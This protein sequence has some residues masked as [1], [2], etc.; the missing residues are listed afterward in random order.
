[1]KKVLVSFFVLLSIMSLAQDE[2]VSTEKHNKG[3]MSVYWG[4][5]RGFYSNSDIHFSGNDHDFTLSNVVAHD[6]QTPFSLDPYFNP[7]LVTIPQTNFRIGYFISDKWEISIGVD[8][9]KYVMDQNQYVAING[10]INGVDNDFNGV[11]NGEEIQLTEA[12]LTFEHTDG[13]NYA[14]IEINRF[15]NIVQFGDRSNFDID[16]NVLGG[17]GAGVMFPKSNVMLFAKNRYDEFHTAGFGLSAKIGLNITF[18]NYFFLQNEYKVGYI[19][20][21]D[22]LT[23]TQ[24]DYRADQDFF[25]SQINIVFG[26]IFPIVRS[27]KE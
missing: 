16:I 20:M 13:L 14:N 2:V 27:N 9:M 4:W 26:A 6:R 19:N 24:S 25:F 11:Y 10:E 7:G 15:E 8:H 1:M 12:F 18:W 23:S 22:I 5:N 21:P 3:K 17:V